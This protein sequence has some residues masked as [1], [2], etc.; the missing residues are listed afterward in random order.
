MAI[1]T[2]LVCFGA[3][4]FTAATIEHYLPMLNVLNLPDPAVAIAGGVLATLASAIKLN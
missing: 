4:A 1:G 3:G 2:A